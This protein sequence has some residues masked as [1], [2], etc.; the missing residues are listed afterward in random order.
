M[1][2]KVRTFEDAWDDALELI[3]IHYPG[4]EAHFA[5]LTP[6]SW[7]GEELVAQ[8]A[9]RYTVDLFAHPRWWLGV[10]D[11]INFAFGVGHRAKF[12]V[13]LAPQT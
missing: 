12:R 8:S 4:Y 3:N 2:Q 13:V 5:N 1:M 6:I 10:G 11:H 7:D 9:N